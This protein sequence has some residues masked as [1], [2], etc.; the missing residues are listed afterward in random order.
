MDTQKAIKALNKLIEINNDRITGYE[1]A[2]KETNEL[3]LKALFNQMANTSTECRAALVKE[4]LL[5]GGEPTEATT[6]S[7]K[8]FRAWMDVKAA[9]S[10][11]DRGAILDSC[12]YGDDNA[13]ETYEDVLEDDLQYLSADQHTMIRDQYDLLTRDHDHIR[14]LRDEEITR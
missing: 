2:S 7:G 1:K 6:T 9:I 5:L 12:E 14:S 4:V 8:F 11:N 3:D 10:G 13:K